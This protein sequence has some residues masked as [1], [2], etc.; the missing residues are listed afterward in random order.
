MKTFSN[1]LSR[2]QKVQAKLQ[3]GQWALFHQKANLCY[4]DFEDADFLLLS[5][6]KVYY[7]VR[8]KS[9]VEKLWTGQTTISYECGVQ[10][11]SKDILAFLQKIKFKELFSDLIL[12][13]S[14]RANNPLCPEANILASE[15]PK[16]KLKSATPIIA[17]LRMVKEKQELQKIRKAN[18]LTRK[19]ISHL[20]PFLKTG[21]MEY[22]LKAEFDYFL[23]RSGALAQAFTPIIACDSSSCILHKQGYAGKMHNNVLFDLGA[24][25]QNYCADISR[26]YFLQPTDLQEKALQLVKKA[27]EE[28]IRQAKPGLLL[29]DLHEICTRVLAD[30]LLQMQIITDESQLKKFFMHN[31]SHHLGIET[32]DLSLAD[33]PLQENMVITVEPG[34][35]FWQ[36]GFGIRIEDDIII[37]KSGAE[38]IGEI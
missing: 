17:P 19:A 12:S 8:S 32:H 2:A 5:A 20:Q 28:V 29:K 14:Q 25:Y 6:K 3:E 26:S 1:S 35:Y 10:K 18:H 13:Q 37:T 38:L 21:V 24:K 11:E 36:K 31:V 16:E 9:K 27:Q 4:L 15:F 23:T 7:F 22:E 30:G 34:L 33:L